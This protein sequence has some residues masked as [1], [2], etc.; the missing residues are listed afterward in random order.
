MKQILCSHGF[1]VAADSRGMFPEIAAAFTGHT[2]RMFDYNEVRPNGDTLVRS[3][4]EQAEI[5]QQQIDQCEAGLTLLCHS[6]GSVIAGLVDLSRVGKVILL[7][8]PVKMSMQRLIER[9]KARK[10]SRID[11]GGMS[12]LP[13]SDGTISYLPASYLQ[14]LKDRDPL[15]LYQSIADSVP[16]T[17]I[18][19]TQDEI[20][21]LTN[22]DT[23]KNAVH[24][25]I[26]ADHNF[27]GIHREQLIS[28]LGDL[29]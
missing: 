5:L 13:R 21:G 17:I 19:A 9:M 11:I 1:G 28:A 16:T 24:I 20:V 27:T 8:P 12:V 18:R 22:V 4:D 2:F 23:V 15:A 14:T 3:L 29:L 10:G 26:A 7:A 25:D 6:Q